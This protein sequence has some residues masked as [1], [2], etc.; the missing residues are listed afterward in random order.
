MHIVRKRSLW[1]RAKE[2][3]KEWARMRELERFGVGEFSDEEITEKTAYIRNLMRR[4][5]TPV[6]PLISVVIPAHNEVKYI[7]ATLRSLAEQTYQ[8]CE[9]VIVSNGEPEGNLTQRMAE[10]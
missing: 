7:L 10:A 9:F 2:T 8:N 1:M 5:A 6:H 3:L 4:R